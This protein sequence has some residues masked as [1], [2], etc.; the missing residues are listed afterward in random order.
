[1]KDVAIQIVNYNTKKYLIDCIDG[2]FADLQ[3]SNLQYEVLVLDNASS[4]DL[5][6]L[7]VRYGNKVSVFRSDKNKGF[8]G[9]HN[10]LAVRSK[11]PFILILNPDIK[12]IEPRTIER[13]MDRVKAGKKYAVVGPKLVTGSGVVQEWDHGELRGLQAW[14]ANHIGR[15]YW[16]DRDQEGAVAWVSGAFFL[17]RRDV[18]E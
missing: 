15:S 3:G 7:Q 18:F 13:L 6:D 11:A 17:I 1:M 8:G 14:V 4:D 16:K 2:V 9:G 12:F 10:D 5:K